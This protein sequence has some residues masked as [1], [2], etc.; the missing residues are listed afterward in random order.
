M[1][2]ESWLLFTL[3][4][5]VA[6]ISPGPNVLIVMIHSLKYGWRASM[7]TIVGNVVCL[8]G[9]ALLAALGVGALIKAEP[10]AYTIL[11]TA[12]AAYLIY[13]GI[14]M[15]RS[16]FT[17]LGKGLVLPGPDEQ[18]PRPSAFSLASQ[19]FLVSASNPKSVIF[20]SA[21][22]PLFL[23]E[24]EPLIGQFTIM[25]ATIIMLVMIVHWT[26]AI[27]ASA[28]RRKIVRP[29]TRAIISRIT[30]GSFIALGGGVL[31]SD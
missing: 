7:F 16:S 15:I 26:Y 18:G 10:L 31:L 24:S 28:L 20:L 25:F 29:Q 2:L 5:T 22:F 11:K 12:G 4:V 23:N 27:I 21:I 3:A 6:S 17:I 14:K 8:F 1:T 9:I 30:G 19:S 13:L